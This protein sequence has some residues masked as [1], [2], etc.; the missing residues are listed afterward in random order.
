M[1]NITLIPLTFFL[2]TSSLLFSQDKYIELLISDETEIEAEE[3]YYKLTVSPLLP[4]SNKSHLDLNT[5]ESIIKSINGVEEN[6]NIYNMPRVNRNSPIVKNLRLKSKESLQQ[7]NFALEDYSNI[8]GY[9][10]SLEHSKTDSLFL[11]LTDKVVAKAK[12]K[13]ENLAK[14]MEA[15]LVEIVEISEFGS[16]IF[17]NQNADLDNSNKVVIIPE[18]ESNNIRFKSTKLILIKKLRFKFKMK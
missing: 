18:F 7:L 10:T 11:D 5:I 13:A 9:I 16:T 17:L 12:K 15:D 2:L 4:R 8:A 1:K 6:E 3:I 14:L